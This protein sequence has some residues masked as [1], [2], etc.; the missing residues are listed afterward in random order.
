[1]PAVSFEDIFEAS[2]KESISI[3]LG[4]IALKSINFYFEPKILARNPAKFSEAFRKLFGNTAT[5]LEKMVRENLGSKTGVPIDQ[6]RSLDFR[7]FVRAAKTEFVSRTSKSARI[8]GQN[9]RPALPT[10]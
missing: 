9:R 4:N 1:M 6:Q 10:E 8:T 7:S 5:M 3:L 2:V